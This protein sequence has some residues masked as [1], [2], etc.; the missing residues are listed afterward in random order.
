MTGGVLVGEIAHIQGPLPASPR[1]NPDMTNEQRRE[2]ENL[3]MLC[4]THHTIIDTAVDEWSVSKLQDLKSSHE[5]RATVISPAVQ[6]M[7]ASAPVLPIEA[8]V[9]A[10]PPFVGREIEMQGVAA[11][12]GAAGAGTVTSSRVNI[13]TKLVMVRVSP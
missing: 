12:L 2:Y 5:A 7:G 6:D 13:K 10:G 11:A 4:G 8:M 1:F 3:L 9:I